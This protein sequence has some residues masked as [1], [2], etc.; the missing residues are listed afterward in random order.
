MTRASR[1]DPAGNVAWPASVMIANEAASRSTRQEAPKPVPGP[2]TSMGA[3][4]SGRCPPIETRSDEASAGNP[5]ARAS[6]S[7]RRCTALKPNSF[8]MSPASMVQELLVRAARLF[9]TEARLSFVAP[10]LA[11]LP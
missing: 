9:S 1:S 6:K 7:L 2:T 4:A 10:D 5:Q 8:L 11:A 3:P